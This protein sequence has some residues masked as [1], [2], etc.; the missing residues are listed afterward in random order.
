M[1]LFDILTNY[2]STEEDLERY[3]EECK[4]NDDQCYLEEVLNETEHHP[5]GITVEIHP[6][7]YVMIEVR[8]SFVPILLQNGFNT[9]EH[10]LKPSKAGTA[11][12]ASLLFTNV[13]VFN[14]LID[15]LSEDE[16]HEIGE[17]NNGSR[18][19]TDVMFMV[20]NLE[21]FDRALELWPDAINKIKPIGNVF[22]IFAEIGTSLEVFERIL[23]LVNNSEELLMQQNIGS[24]TPLMLL[25]YANTL[26][27]SDIK[28]CIISRM[29]EIAG[30]EVLYIE[31][32]R[33]V[34]P[35]LSLVKSAPFDVVSTILDYITPDRYNDIGNGI[36]LTHAALLNNDIEVLTYVLGL[37]GTK[38]HL[39][40]PNMI[41][42]YPLHT[43]LYLCKDSN[44]F[45]DFV[46]SVKVKLILNTLREMNENFVTTE[47]NRMDE[48]TEFYPIHVAINRGLT[49]CLDILI[50]EDP[51]QLNLCI[52]GMPC[53]GLVALTKK[54]NDRIVMMLLNNGCYE[55]L[56]STY[57]RND[58]RYTPKSILESK[59]EYTDDEI[60]YITNK[61]MERHPDAPEEVIST[62]VDL[63]IRMTIDI[64]NARKNASMKVINDWCEANN[65]EPLFE[66]DQE[67]C[68]PLSCACCDGVATG[69]TSFQGNP[70][71]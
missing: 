11:L 51:D 36:K 66:V 32:D 1:A 52:E 69:V 29:V 64:D 20:D 30:G 68:V 19:I 54:F 18:N 53:M 10:I 8:I 43:T 33:Q 23:E 38:E 4:E 41:G 39:L 12:C 3:F 56:F 45:S 46:L 14:S 6:L 2:D 26:M 48:E 60:Q 15:C 44:G 7:T 63:S 31:N 71:T 17:N 70:Q 35:V 22:H 40:D 65:K 5:D 67:N 55:Q 58:T 9:A 50:K 42:D 28:S 25:L 13:E 24:D 61:A 62:I 47:L 21:K 57:A 59:K 27:E 34:N 37:E 49:N 16:I